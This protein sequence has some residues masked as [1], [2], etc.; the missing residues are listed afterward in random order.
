MIWLVIDVFAG[1]P[2]EGV[3]FREPE[4][5][6]LATIFFGLIAGAV[7]QLLGDERARELLWRAL[8]V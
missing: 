6:V 8:P 7:V 1:K 5:L 3:G 2:D 4:L